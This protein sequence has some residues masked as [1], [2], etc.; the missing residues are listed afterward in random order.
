M[1]ELNQSVPSGFVNQHLEYTHGY[2]AVLAPISQSGVNADGTPDFSLS[3]LP[4]TG[5][6]SAERDRVRRS[7]TAIGPDTGGYVIADSKTP[8][9]D[10]ENS[11]TGSQVTNK[12]TGKGGVTAGSIVRRAAFA[13][14][15][16]DPNFIL[17]GQINPS[18]RVMYIRNIN[19]RVR[20]AAPFLKF[21]ADPYAVIL[22][23]KVYW[24]IDAYTTTD[25]YPYAQN[26]DTT[27]VPAYERA[28]HRR[29][30]TCATRSR[31]SSAPTTDRCTSS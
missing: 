9:L 31:S 8:E 25:N 15:F 10:Y 5:T 18:S 27:G 23:G 7:T 14:R 26:A 17:S 29:S 20:K 13:L 30:T 3:D 12:Y 19:D 16:G 11:T 6:P 1:R 28:C 21:D 24:V 22:N 4:P 2:G